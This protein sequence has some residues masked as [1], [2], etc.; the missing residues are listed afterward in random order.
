[1]TV[2][3]MVINKHLPFHLDGV[4]TPTLIELDH[5]IFTCNKTGAVKY[6]A[7][8]RDGESK[9]TYRIEIQ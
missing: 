5:T 9:R 3:D 1:M 8:T 2:D 7:T 4:T 6:P